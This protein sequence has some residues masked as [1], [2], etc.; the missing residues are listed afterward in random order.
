MNNTLLQLMLNAGFILADEG[1]ESSVFISR[2]N[3]QC[4]YT[5]TTDNMLDLQGKFQKELL[6][7]GIALDA[8]N[9][10]INFTSDIMVTKRY[11]LVQVKFYSKAEKI[12][13]IDVIKSTVLIST[14]VIIHNSQ[15]RI[16]GTVNDRGRPIGAS[17]VDTKVRSMGMV[18][19]NEPL[20]FTNAPELASVVALNNALDRGS[21]TLSLNDAGNFLAPQDSENSSD[22]Y[23]LAIPVVD[24][25]L[26]NLIESGG[27]LKLSL[28]RFNGNISIFTLNTIEGGFVAK[29]EYYE[30]SFSKVEAKPVVQTVSI[31]S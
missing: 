11:N 10:L 20:D 7:R 15:L 5:M 22:G 14:S 1:K 31:F 24:F 8:I 21:V 30:D 19:N 29:A 25:I 2:E 17:S 26:P 9:S 3:G 18:S 13:I 16:R 27:Q 6:Q 12:E 23:H 4:N 28:T